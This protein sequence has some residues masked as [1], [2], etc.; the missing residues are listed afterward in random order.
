MGVLSGAS[1]D[2]RRDSRRDA[3]IFGQLNE[4]QH[5]VCGHGVHARYVT[6]CNRPE[7]LEWQR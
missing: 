5:D 3:L 4:N 7:S 2:C 6:I 1:T